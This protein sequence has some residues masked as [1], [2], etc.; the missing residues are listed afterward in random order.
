M[1]AV[2]HLL[3][4]DNFDEK[5]LEVFKDIVGA[6]NKEVIKGFVDFYKLKAEL[7]GDILHIF[8]FFS[9]KNAFLKIAEH[10]LET[11][12]T[13]TVFP[14]EK[15]LQMLLKENEHLLE[16]AQREINRS[17]YIILSIIALILGGVAGYI[18]FKILEN[19]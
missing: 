2:K 4:I 18:L 3:K 14:R 1:G 6:E 7:K 9:E 13:K 16:E 12:E 11:G 8:M 5:I 15:F 10:N 17:A 19:I